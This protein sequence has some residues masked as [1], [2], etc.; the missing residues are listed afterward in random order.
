MDENKEIEPKL[1]RETGKGDLSGNVCPVCG[2]AGIPDYLATDTVCPQCGSDLSI[3]RVIVDDAENHRKAQTKIKSR[4]HLL[5]SSLLAAGAAAAVFLV[6]FVA[7]PTH[8]AEIETLQAQ[9]SALTDSLNQARADVIHTDGGDKKT[10]TFVYTVRRGD[11]YWSVARKVYGE[12]TRWTQIRDAN[13]DLA[14]PLQIGQQ[15]RIPQ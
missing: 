14:L 12:P 6:L 3:F 11:C 1:G 7:K 8:K 10:G 13:R 5:L 9:V 2:K 15:L 4:Q